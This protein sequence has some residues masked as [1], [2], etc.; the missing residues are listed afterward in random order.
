[1]RDLELGDAGTPP[2][3]VCSCAESTSRTTVSVCRHHQHVYHRKD[4]YSSA[5]DG[6][7]HLPRW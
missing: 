5:K 7:P 2:L 1:M 3:F 6:L 4:Y